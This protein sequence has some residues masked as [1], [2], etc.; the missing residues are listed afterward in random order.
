MLADCHDI[1]HRGVE[2]LLGQ[3]GLAHEVVQVAHERGHDLFESW[4]RR[5]LQLRQDRDG[6]VFLVFDDHGSPFLCVGEFALLTSNAAIVEIAVALDVHGQE[7]AVVRKILVFR[8][9]YVPFRVGIALALLGRLFH[10]GR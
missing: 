1:S 7:G 8:Q 6:D 9:L 3:L 4:I 2:L 5:A 10:G